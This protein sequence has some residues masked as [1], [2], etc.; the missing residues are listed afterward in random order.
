MLQQHQVELAA[1]HV[2]GVIP[3]DARLFALVKAYV[4]MAIRSQP[5]PSQLVGNL[6]LVVRGPDCAKLVGKLC[7]FHLRKKIEVFEHARRSRAQRL[8]DM[9][10]GKT[11]ALNHAATYA[12]LG[13]V[14][15]HRGSG[16][17]SANN[18]D[19][20]IRLGNKQCF[21]PAYSNDSMPLRGSAYAARPLCLQRAKFARN[22]TSGIGT[23]GTKFGTIW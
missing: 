10:P 17:P 23:D 15:A 14:S 19:I 5:L 16:R 4:S 11:L 12:S 22:S 8:A 3:V 6:L 9:R 7:F 21:V 18:R 13:Q 20:E 2:A 1:V